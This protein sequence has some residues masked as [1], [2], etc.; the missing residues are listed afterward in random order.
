M[1]WEAIGAI[2]EIV[3]ALAVFLTL[4]YLAMQIRQNTKAVRASAIDSSVNSI[5]AIRSK[6][7]ESEE[8]TDIYVRGSEDPES[9]SATEIIRYRVLLT[10]ILWGALN[11]HS[12][13]K[14]ADLSESMWECQKPL[15][16]RILDSPGGRWYWREYSHEL[17]SSF[18]I[19]IN[20]I[21]E[22]PSA[23]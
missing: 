9:L 2:G 15:I 8:V 21:I 20:K 17:E 22:I 19:E 5:S 12:Q 6:V 23:E 13:S 1:N 14:Y 16:R 4:A 10:N 7:L 11:L 18:V 3:G